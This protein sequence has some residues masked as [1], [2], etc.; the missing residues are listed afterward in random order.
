P[1]PTSFQA[2]ARISVFGD[3]DWCSAVSTSDLAAAATA[4]LTEALGLWR[5]PALGDV[6][7]APYAGAVV[8]RLDDLRAAA[9]ED[10]FDAELRLGRHGAVLSDLD[11]A[12]AAHPLRERLAALRIR[13]L[14]A[15]GRQSDALAVYEDMRE[16]LGEELGIDPSAELRDTHLALLRGE[17]ETPSARKEPAGSALPARLTSFVGRE[18]E[19]AAVAGQLAAARLVTL[20]GPGGAGKTRLA[21]EAMSRRAGEPVF[22]VPLAEVGTPDQLA[23]AVSGAL[24][25]A[26][27]PTGAGAARLTELLDVGAAV[28]VLDNC[29]HVIAAAAELAAHL[30]ARLPLLR[31]LATSREPLAID[32]ETLCHV[33]PLQV[34]DQVLDPEAAQRNPA[35][36]L[37]LDRAA[38]VRPGFTLDDQNLNPVLEICRQLDGIPLALELA[39][40]KLRAM[41]VDQIARRL[42]DRFR[43][44]TSGSRTALPRQRTLLALVE[45]SWDLLEEPEKLLARRL[46][47]FP[48]GATLEALEAICADAD[49]PAGDILYVLGAL[50]EKSLVTVS[51]DDQPRYRMLETIR[52]YAA[53]RRAAA[54]EDLASRFTTHYLAQAEAAEPGLRTREQLTAIAFFD[55]E[56]PNLVLALRTALA[57]AE[58]EENRPDRT[59]RGGHPGL[60]SESADGIAGDYS[61]A[62][63]RGN[64]SDTCH[65]RDPAVRPVVS[66]SPNGGRDGVV[67][68]DLTG[69]AESGSC[70]AARF[71]RALFWYWGIRG[72]SSR[73][74]AAVRD[75]LRLELPPDVRAAFRV[76]R[77]MA[78][79]PT[80]ET[81]AVRELIEDCVR[82]GALEF[83]PALPLWTSLVAS[84]AGEDELA[85]RQLAQAVGRSD[86]WVRAS[87]HLARDLALTGR[88]EPIAGAAERREAL[89][90]FEITGERWGLGVVLLG[91]GRAHGLAGEHER[92]IAAFAR[93]VALASETGM[94][95]D[96]FVSRA[97]L[98]RARMRAGDL[99]GAAADIEAAQRQSE[100]LGYARLREVLGFSR[101]EAYRRT[102]EV[103]RAAAELDRLEQRIERLPLPE[104]MAVNR[105]SIARLANHLTARRPEQA[106]ELLPAVIEGAFHAGDVAAVTQALAHAA[107]LLAEL[108]FHEG[109]FTG[110][111]SA[112]GLSEAI[113]GEF[114]HG[115]PQLRTLS[116]ELTS[117]L[118]SEPFRTAYDRGAA[119][120][121]T[122]AIGQLR[123][124]HA[125]P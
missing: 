28:L 100:E 69:V 51:G 68:A 30:L 65:R 47:Y 32:G 74:E 34:P 76:I 64:P 125:E 91:I 6:L 72:M 73:F 31:I 113:R 50:V 11:A 105:I 122:V 121:R 10:R 53:D 5:G 25:A 42:D 62:V 104:V 85:E 98:T 83:H 95:D 33:G 4:A 8:A 61:H 56:H 40:A 118:G 82:T 27:G 67:G 77:L 46:S 19:L 109:E 88:G 119:T 13:A 75:V 63:S 123:A 66:D 97:E 106:R 60:A 80:G 57:A 89:R 35:V 2:N 3:G 86:P 116:T 94:E 124:A 102:G 16:R 39:A 21:L 93:A 44:L 78:G 84:G 36:R 18:Q 71:T 17:L 9:L 1:S 29:E 7:D 111:A 92:A 52:A 87:A 120:P 38:A 59:V 110:S 26:D 23:D 90:A 22:F 107:E 117:R 43:L 108:L 45:W 20:V 101:A 48:A 58:S 41:G 14:A 112:L 103:E 99:T 96:L 81:E 54:A 15:G 37:F 55:A 114:D 49:L 70:L 79:A 24:A 12:G 115:E